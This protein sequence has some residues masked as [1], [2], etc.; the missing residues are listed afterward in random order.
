MRGQR[1][2][3]I[4]VASLFLGSLSLIY[5]SM[6]AV[7]GGRRVRIH[8]V[9]EVYRHYFIL[10]GIGVAGLML[11]LGLGLIFAFFPALIGRRRNYR[12]IVESV[13]V[14]S[15]EG[16]ILFGA[17]PDE[18]AGEVRAR[19]TIDGV[20]EEYAC[21]RPAYV[22]MLRA[23]SGMATIDGGLIVSFTPYSTANS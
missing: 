11:S 4:L 12:A 18:M 16:H 3:E 22:K 21:R 20:T 5:F 2:A 9:G 14:S 1:W 17:H 8:E 19:L 15:N 10:I 23:S 6:G 7:N 13:F